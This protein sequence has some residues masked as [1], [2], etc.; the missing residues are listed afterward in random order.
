LICMQSIY[1]I[2]KM[3]SEKT[4]FLALLGKLLK[5]IFYLR[6]YNSI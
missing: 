4:Y 5:W 6:S 1:A 2:I 3:F